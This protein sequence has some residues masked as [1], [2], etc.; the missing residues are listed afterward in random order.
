MANAVYPGKAVHVATESSPTGNHD[1]LCDK[2]EL[3]TEALIQ[4]SIQVTEGLKL[5]QQEN[6]DLK[7]TIQEQEKK[8]DA[9]LM[10]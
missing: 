3:N 2:D 4:K 1:P 9:L 7:V 10:R 6:S 5:L 8:Y